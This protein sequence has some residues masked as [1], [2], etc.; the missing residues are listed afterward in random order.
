MQTHVKQGELNLTQSLQ[1]TLEVFG[2]QHFVEEFA[3]QWFASVDMGCH[4]AQDRP[5]PTKV[6]HE[7]A[8][9]FNS[10]PFHAAD[11]RNITLVDL[12]E[13]MV[14]AVAALV[15][16]GDHIVMRQQWRF[17]TSTFGEVTHQMRDW[18]LQLLIVW[19]QPPRTHIVHP[20]A[21][22]FARTRTWV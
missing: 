14:Q 21:T 5:F 22:A 18:G 1:A 16:E 8:R 20:C 3:W 4:M 19:P 11:A 15:E 2:G 6:F 12:R 13:H 17:A 9:K 7:L 10:V